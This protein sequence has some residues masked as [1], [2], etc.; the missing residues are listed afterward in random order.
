MRFG[1]YLTLMIAILP[2]VLTRPFFGL[3]AY[4][5]V[6][7]TAR[8]SD[9]RLVR[10]SYAVVALSVAF[11]AIKGGLKVILLGPH[12]VYGR[13]YDNNLF[14]LTSVMTLP[15]VFYFALSVKHARWRAILFA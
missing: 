4:Y 9:Y 8:A 7:L 10:V 15:M 2:I 13:T 14:A 6:S 1:I 5:V 11:W 12:Q 3:C